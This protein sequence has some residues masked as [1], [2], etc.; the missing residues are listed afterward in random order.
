MKWCGIEVL[1]VGRMEVQTME[2]LCVKEFRGTIGQYKKVRSY[3]I[4]FYNKLS[5]CIV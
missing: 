3:I 2:K 1:P 4:S 5:I